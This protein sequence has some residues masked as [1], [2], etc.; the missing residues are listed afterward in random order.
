MHT[1]RHAFQDQKRGNSTGNTLL[2]LLTERRGLGASDAR[3]MIYAHLGLASDYA[4]QKF[5]FDVDYSKSP[6]EVFTEVAQFFLKMHK[7]YRLLDCLEDRNPTNRRRGLASWAPDWTTKNSLL[8]AKGLWLGHG[9]VKCQP[10]PRFYVS[11]SNE[12]I[13]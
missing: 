3:D 10:A 13:A 1:A 9:E 2:N 7:D 6:G 5:L 4:S 12:K 8:P 11:I